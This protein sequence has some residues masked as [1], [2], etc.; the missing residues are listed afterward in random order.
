MAKI[1]EKKLIAELKKLKEIKPNQSWVVFTKNR[2][3]SEEPVCQTEFSFARLGKRLNDLIKELQRG[4][5]FVF[6]HK[7][8]FSSVLLLVVLVGMFGFAQQSVP[9]D[10]LFT[11]KKLTEQGQGAFLTNKSSHSFEIAEKR[12]DDLIKIAES[13]SIDNL[14]PA[15]VE[16]SETVSK[17]AQEITESE[18]IGNI[19]EEVKK[20]QEKENKIRSYGIEIENS[21]KLDNALAKIVE[22]EIN[23]LKERELTEEQQE[24]LSEIEK[25]FENKE[26]SAALEKILTA[27]GSN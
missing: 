4:E 7:L 17:V 1:T 12:L 3:V 13:N 14:A 24:A 25:D 21:E 15:L 18:G 26:Y 20:L 5:R 16:Y 2:I 8:A 9:G 22:R 27:V 10:S 6:Q 11:I 23:V 19:A